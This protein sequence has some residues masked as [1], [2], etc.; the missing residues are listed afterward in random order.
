MNNNGRK[1]GGAGAGAC[2]ICLASLATGL[3]WII[4]VYRP[5]AL[6]HNFKNLQDS[7]QLQLQ[8]WALEQSAPFV[9]LDLVRRHSLVIARCFGVAARCTCWRW[10]RC[11]LW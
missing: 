11:W 4:F 3:W 8:N 7:V 5:E 2:F 10:S 6:D 9:R 1:G